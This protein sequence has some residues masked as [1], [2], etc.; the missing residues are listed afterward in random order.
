MYIYRTSYAR[1]LS[2]E[3]LKEVRLP[4]VSVFEGTSREAEGDEDGDEFPLRSIRS[5]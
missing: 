4:A 3:S 5:L 2:C 1:L